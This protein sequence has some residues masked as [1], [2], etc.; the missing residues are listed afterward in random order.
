MNIND[1]YCG[2]F[3]MNHPIA[4]T[5]PVKADAAIQFATNLLTSIHVAI[6]HE[7]TVA[8]LGTEEGHIKKVGRLFSLESSFQLSVIFGLLPPPPSFPF[9]NSLFSIE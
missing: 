7:Y 1:N 3:E 5:Y 6:T 2:D 9:S 4:G 8:F